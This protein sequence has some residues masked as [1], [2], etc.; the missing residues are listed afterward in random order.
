MKTLKSL[1]LGTS[2]I[3]ATV[4]AATVVVVAP[5]QAAGLKGSLGLSGNIT[6]TNDG[7]NF[8][9]EFSENVVN[10]NTLDFAGLSFPTDGSLPN[11]AN[12]DFTCVG[13]L[14]ST[15]PVT[16]FITFG[17]QTINGVT[18]NLT[19]NLDASQYLHFGSGKTASTVAF[20]L[21]TG[22]FM[23]NGSTLAEGTLGG[24]YSGSGSTYHMNFST[25]VPEPLTTLGTGLALGFGGLFQRKN[26]RRK[27]KKQA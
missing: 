2:L 13:I 8:T 6:I 5:A 26:S 18:D 12:L 14:C 22:N 15:D 9:W 27:N 1:G 25:P 20:P 23:F 21:I 19:F 16:A 4:T 3:A 10:D 11:I 17:E 7:D 24:S